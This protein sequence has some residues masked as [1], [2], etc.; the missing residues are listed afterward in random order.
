MNSQLILKTKIWEN[1]TLNLINYSNSEAKITKMKINTSGILSRNGKTLLFTEGEYQ[2][3]SPDDLLSIKQNTQK[4]KYIIKFRNYSKDL[5]E[6]V[7]EQGAFLVYRGFYSQKFVDSNCK[8]HKLHQGDIFKLG[9]IYFKVLDIYLN[10]ESTVLNTN[11]DN[12]SNGSMSKNSSYSRIVNGQQVI[13]GSFSSYTRNKNINKV[14]DNNKSHILNIK[15][16]CIKN[17]SYDSFTYKK[18]TILPKININNQLISIIKNKRYKIRNRSDK[19]N[20]ELILKKN[21][22]IKTKNKT[23]C[24]ICYRDYSDDKDPL[25]SPCICKGSM[26]YIHYKCLKNWLNSKIEN[27][28]NNNDNDKINSITYKRKDISC[29]LCK[30]ILPDYIKHNNLYYNISFYKPKF[31]E[32]IVL[33]S[34]QTI[35]E[36]KIKYIHIISLDNKKSIIIGRDNECELSLNNLFISRYHCFIRKREGELFLEDNLS[37]YGTLV[38][39][40]NNNIIMNDLLPLKIQINNIYIKIKVSLPISF[41]C[42]DNHGYQN[43]SELNSYNCQIQNKENFNIFSYLNIKEDD[44]S[45]DDEENNSEKEKKEESL[46]SNN[47]SRLLIDDNNSESKKKIDKIVQKENEKKDNNSIVKFEMNSSYFSPRLRFKNLSIKKE[48]ENK[49]ELPNFDDIKKDL[50]KDNT[51]LNLNMSKISQM[52]FN[53]QYK[54][55]TIN[56]IKIRKNNRN[57]E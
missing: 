4:G 30:E 14:L 26:K 45:S 16:S 52:V 53:S 50:F 38:L 15:K 21:N 57:K 12:N 41:K 24:R 1:E 35:N 47:I 28:I 56:L 18:K 23:I 19:K 6:L 5:N 55:K 2:P 54:T 10:E 44:V 22:N 34:I 11:E 13:K 46:N 43:S 27:D 9:K 29:E 7:E 31:K 33:E 17:E 25:I 40:Q 8:Y 39:I 42:C 32:F 48:K 20:Q 37:K 3:E 36:E 49:Y 51:R